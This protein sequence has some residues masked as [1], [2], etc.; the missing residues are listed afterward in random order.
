MGALI[1]ADFDHRRLRIDKLLDG[2]D[3]LER[4]F[5]MDLL[6]VL[7][8]LEHIVDELLRHLAPQPHAV[9]AIVHLDRVDI[10]VLERGRRL[11]D[12]NGLLELKP[13]HQLLA[14]RELQPRIAVIRLPL[15]NGL[16]VLQGVAVIQDGGVRQRSP[17]IC[18]VGE[19]GNTFS[20][21]LSHP[22][23]RGTGLVGTDCTDGERTD[24]GVGG[25]QLQRLR[26]IGDRE[27]VGFEF[28]MGLGCSC[29]QQES[30]T[31][32]PVR[33]TWAL[34][35]KNDGSRSYLAMAWE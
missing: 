24:L 33:H 2:L 30:H 4:I 22:R 28:D 17:P 20:F 7:E 19:S 15:D 12:L 3:N 5:A 6:P 14:V 25:I 11:G 1:D 18:L 8:P 23:V 21:Y 16:K 35:L 13:A 26:G 29:C 27:A 32:R 31:F 34:L 9:I 10:Q